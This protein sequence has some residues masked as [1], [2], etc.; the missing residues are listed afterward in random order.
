MAWIAI[1]QGCDDSTSAGGGG[2]D[3]PDSFEAVVVASD[4]G[5][6][7]GAVVRIR[8]ERWTARSGAAPA[9]WE[10]RTGTDGRF[11]L[12][13]PDT[14]RWSLE[15]LAPS[16]DEGRF[17][18]SVG[19]SLLRLLAPRVVLAPFAR[20]AGSIP[21]V[22]PD[23]SG[24]ILLEG[25]DRNVSPGASGAWILR[26]LGPGTYRVVWA[27]PE[28]DTI[29]RDQVILGPSDS[30]QLDSTSLADAPLVLAGR[31][32]PV[33]G[34]EPSPLPI[35]GWQVS[36]AGDTTKATTDANGEFRLPTTR[37]G[38]VRIVAT[39]PPTGETATWD[40]IL[41][42]SATGSMRLVPR[43]A[44]RLL[45][46]ASYV[47][48]AVANP[49]RIRRPLRVRVAADT[50]A[51]RST[52]MPSADRAQLPAMVGWT[53]D[54]G[55]FALRIE[56]VQ[57]F[58]AT[59]SD[60]I[61]GI[62]AVFPWSGGTHSV[63][64]GTIRVGAPGSATVAVRFP[65]GTSSQVT[66]GGLLISSMGT[67]LLAQ[68]VLAGA[69]T[70]F[71]SLYPGSHRLAVVSLQTSQP[72]AGWVDARI[73]EATNLVI[74]TLLAQEQIE[75]TADWPLAT[76]LS[77]ESPVGAPT[78]R[79]VTVRMDLA[80]VLDLP[81]YPASD[82]GSSLRFHDESG[83][84]VPAVATR[85]SPN[86]GIATFAVLLDSLPTG[87]RSLVLRHGN[88]GASIG[89][90]ALPRSVFRRE[91]GYLAHF[92]GGTS[93][94]VAG[95]SSLVTEGLAYEPGTETSQ[96]FSFTSATRAH[97]TMPSESL[98]T[99]FGVQMVVRPSAA[100][101]DSE[102]FLGLRALPGGI[103]VAVLGTRAGKTTLRLWDPDS[104]AREHVLDDLQIP[105]GSRGVMALRRRGDSLEVEVDS[106]SAT[107]IRRLAMAWPTATDSVEFAAGATSDASGG[108]TG[109][110]DALDLHDGSWT[111]ARA[112]FEASWWTAG[113]HVVAKK[114][115]R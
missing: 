111:G 22:G 17:L 34:W 103:D 83:R 25:T 33:V 60:S 101:A 31:L 23:S 38:E 5:P 8:P 3:V 64:P 108:F 2:T 44:R 30:V 72:I 91:A 39:H 112:A 29:L 6:A 79:T 96:A 18:P 107:A 61:E 73:E 63:S 43:A 97:L 46:T 114:R 32:A 89:G 58:H 27:R 67:P 109:T 105:R 28:R 19:D 71:P 53:D 45:D 49:D 110:V 76:L 57:A 9:A 36:L 69:P 35:A 26:D 88:P 10:T 15:I 51:I 21:S 66:I 78:L 62:G 102:R 7:S 16:R 20:L 55:R 100:P 86:E 94:P 14:G 74:D 70:T 56:R 98:G 84:W 50:T 11:E 85:W 90:Y 65:P 82:L 68:A 80:D 113:A 48:L 75:D 24:T 54:S 59:L 47:F 12:A 104:G 87:G 92:A 42:A 37:R 13:W 77:I 115:L 4:G 106:G 81:A 52:G 1:T 95:G 93:N 40:T 41:A 99:T